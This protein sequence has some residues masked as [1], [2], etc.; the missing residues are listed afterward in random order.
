[1][2][3]DVNTVTGIIK[4]D[5][6]GKTL[7]HE[8]I[9]FGFP[10]YQG[11]LTLG[12]FDHEAAMQSCLEVAERIKAYGVDTVINATPNECGRSPRFLREVAER[13]GLNIICPTGYYF[14]SGGGS[15]YFK[16]RSSLSSLGDIEREITDLFMTEVT[17]G[18]EQTEIK[19]GIFKLASS[20]GRITDYEKVFFRAA[21]KVHQVTRVPIFTH[22][23][24]GTMGPEQVRL[25][26]SLGADP[27]KI[28]ISHMGGSLNI[29]YHLE[30][31]AEG[32]S[33]SF[34]QWGIEEIDN[35]PPE[36]ARLELVLELLSIGYVDQIML[37][38][39][40]VWHWLGRPLN[41]DEYHRELLKN[42]R[43]TY[44][45]EA[46]I[47]HLEQRGVTKEEIETILIDNPR[48][49]FS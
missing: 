31:L 20:K 44:L 48:R 12:P 10:G 1:M 33:I 14:E 5:Q 37:S 22:T 27:K 8:H 26:L 19:A 43:T 9:L 29:D 36:S 47:P 40:S 16:F 35:L 30:T 18:V 4:S 49:F 42:W 2:A 45:F 34:D 23:S 13:S 46:I 3:A 17:V 7:I 38:N 28:L 21:A 25:L 15:A 32:V 24:E 39:D 41:P 6:M 11:D